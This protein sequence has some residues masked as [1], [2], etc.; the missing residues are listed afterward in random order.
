MI[1]SKSIILFGCLLFWSA[2]KVNAQNG[3]VA[4]GGEATGTNGTVS[5]SIGQVNYITANSSAG[6][7]TE[8]LQ[9]PYEI[10]VITGLEKKSILLTA[11]IYPNPTAS[12]VTLSTSDTDVQNMSYGLF[13]IGGKLISQHSLSK[14]Q[15]NISMNGFASGTYFL[16]V[17]NGKTEIKNFK[18][19]KNN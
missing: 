7:I 5:Y 10:S 18:I 3:S 17:L 16:K 1:K 13:D 2:A 6:T 14:K 19:L 8:G 9:Q 15:T 11:T 4:T 12:S